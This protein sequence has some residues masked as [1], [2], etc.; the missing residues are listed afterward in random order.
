M[1]LSNIPEPKTAPLKLGKLIYKTKFYSMY[2]VFDGCYLLDYKV[3]STMGHSFCR[4]QEHYESPKFSGQVFSKEQY[5]KWWKETHSTFSYPHHFLGYNFPGKTFL[6]FLSGDMGDMSILEK[7]LLKSFAYIPE[8][9]FYVIG[10][11]NADVESLTHE[12]AHALFYLN[13]SYRQT[14]LDI[15]TAAPKE[16]HTFCYERL[17][18]AGYMTGVYLDEM[19]AFIGSNGFTSIADITGA[20][21]INPPVTTVSPS[22]YNE[23]VDLQDSLSAHFNKALSVLAKSA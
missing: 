10:A 18:Q 6:P 17:K 1:N 4:F 21:E 19:Q 15:L 23:A 11:T 5:V 14:A 8:S 2:R 7:E 22:I 13:P 12:V 16:L 9:D 20:N 3:T